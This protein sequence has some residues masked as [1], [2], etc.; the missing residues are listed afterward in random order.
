[1]GVQLGAEA[2][3]INEGKRMDRTKS[4][5][6]LTCYDV[7]NSTKGGFDVVE[8]IRWLG[9]ARIC[10]VQ[11]KENPHYPGEG[12]IDFRAVVDALADIAFDEWPSSN[13]LPDIGGGRHARNLEFIRRV[14]AS[15]NGA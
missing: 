12:K 3:K 2:K 8:E 6:V 13:R 1:L 10:E 15:R 9:G 5:A 14:I 4:N 7:G 11:L